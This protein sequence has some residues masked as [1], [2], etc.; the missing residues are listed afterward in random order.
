MLETFFN[1]TIF[2][3]EKPWL[4]GLCS[5]DKGDYSEAWMVKITIKI[6]EI[7]MDVCFFQKKIKYKNYVCPH[8][9]AFFY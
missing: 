9:L 2:L 4:V 7:D 1:K 6:N 8:S 5:G 3:W